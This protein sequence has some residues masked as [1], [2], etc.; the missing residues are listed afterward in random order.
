MWILS[1]TSIMI[2]IMFIIQWPR[3]V[4]TSSIPNRHS[5]VVMNTTIK[6]NAFELYPNVIYLLNFFLFIVLWR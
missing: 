1:L 5:I 4:H 6:S 3:C 2:E